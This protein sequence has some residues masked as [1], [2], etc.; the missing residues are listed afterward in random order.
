MIFLINI[1]E[2]NMHDF[3]NANEMHIF[4]NFNFYQVHFYFNYYY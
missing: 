2:P 4:F 1:Y 3:L